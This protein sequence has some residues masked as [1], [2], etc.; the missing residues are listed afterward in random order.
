M[1]NKT[2][3]FIL[4]CLLLT[5][6]SAVTFSHL[7]NMPIIVSS[8]TEN[9]TGEAQGVIY[10][11]LIFTFSTALFSLIGAIITFPFRLKKRE[12]E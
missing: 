6:S 11:Q 1:I 2:V 7:Y 12:E 4:F 10:F 8:T 5:F 3:V 9:I